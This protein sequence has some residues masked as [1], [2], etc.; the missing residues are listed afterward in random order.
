MLRYGLFGLTLFALIGCAPD[1]ESSLPED[2]LDEANAEEGAVCAL[3]AAGSCRDAGGSA[4]NTSCCVQDLRSTDLEI[5][6][7]ART[8][9][10]TIDVHASRHRSIVLE[11]GDLEIR[12]VTVNGRPAEFQVTDG[13][14]IIS[15]RQRPTLEWGRRVH[16]V[17]VAYA[18][19]VH[20][21]FDGFMDQPLTDMSFTW[22]EF[23]GNLFPCVSHPRDGLRFTLD[24][25]GVPDGQTAIYPREIDFDAPSYQVAFSIGQYEKEVIGVTSAGTEVSLYLLPGEAETVVPAADRLARAFDFFETTYGPYRFGDEVAS[26]S[27]DW[28]DGDFGGME[29]HPFWHITRDSMI[30]SRVHYH[31]AAHGWFGDGIRLSCREDFVLSEGVVTY[32]ESRA[33]EEV[34]DMTN[35]EVWSAVQGRFER[36]IASRDFVIYPDGC[37]QIASLFDLFTNLPYQKGALFM[38]QVEERVGRAKL[39]SALSSF[40]RARV[41]RAAR[42]QD[43]VDHIARETRTSLTDLAQSWLKSTGTPC[44]LQNGVCVK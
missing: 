32:L 26:V 18:F 1:G 13:R 17:R 8:A 28:G 43:L 34:G 22:P 10:A 7:D 42:M 39:D 37:D 16:S 15:D 4:A 11:V 31:E 2:E 3:D 12:E 5:A 19:S 30:N 36:T 33:I 14:L 6:Y 20:P 23:C 35:E 29:H 21:N 44:T 27:V 41:G 24:V 38:R 40:Y 25:T 9:V